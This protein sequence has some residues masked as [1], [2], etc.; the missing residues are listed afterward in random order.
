MRGVALL[1]QELCAAEEGPRAQ[2]P[3]NHVGPLVDFHGK[4]PVGVYPLGEHAPYEGLGG[5]PHDEGLLQFG[6][7]VGYERLGVVGV[8]AQPVVRN[9]RALLGKALHMLCLLGQEGLRDEQGEVGVLRACVS[10]ALVQVVTQQVPDAHAPWLD[11]HAAAYG[12]LVHHVCGVDHVVIPARV[13]LRPGGDHYRVCATGA[14]L[15]RILGRL[16]L[17]AAAAGLGCV[18]GLPTELLVASLERLQLHHLPHH[19]VLVRL[20]SLQVA[21]LVALGFNAGHQGSDLNFRH[22]HEAG[23]PTHLRIGVPNRTVEALPTQSESRGLG[24]AQQHDRDSCR[25]KLHN[26]VTAT[27]LAERR[28]AQSLRPRGNYR[29]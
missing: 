10:D 8:L 22:G 16:L 25:D 20:S 15:G 5:G 23:P 3:S 2:F 6:L 27:V 18:E 26:A 24:Q 12:G 17:T 28:L 9:H 11:D 29:A 14:R 1:P 13:V 7:R 21:D 4:V 19:S